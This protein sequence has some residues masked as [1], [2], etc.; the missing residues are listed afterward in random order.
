MASAID[1]EGDALQ[2]I[3]SP[4]Q[5]VCSPFDMNEEDHG[6]GGCSGDEPG[7]ATVRMKR[8]GGGK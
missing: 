7:I 3:V 5:Y 4:N 6:Q 2:G 8:F 1:A